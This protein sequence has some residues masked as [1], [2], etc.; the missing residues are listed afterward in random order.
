MLK[1]ASRETT[2]IASVG[3]PVAIRTGGLEIRR[4]PT[5]HRSTTAWDLT[6]WQHI[7]WSRLRAPATDYDWQTANDSLSHSV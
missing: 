3:T 5:S 2:F 4:S 1:A 7:P 6:Q